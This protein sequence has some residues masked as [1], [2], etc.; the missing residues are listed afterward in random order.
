MLYTCICSHELNNLLWRTHSR[1]FIVWMKTVFKGNIFSVHRKTWQKHFLTIGN[2]LQVRSGK[3]PPL[4]RNYAL[5]ISTGARIFFRRFVLQLKSHTNILHTSKL[6]SGA[7]GG[8]GGE[9]G[10]F[11]RPPRF[12]LNLVALT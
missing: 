2:F 10:R 5:V 6:L 4:T 9:R 7:F 8:G 11:D 12:S 3:L 1:C